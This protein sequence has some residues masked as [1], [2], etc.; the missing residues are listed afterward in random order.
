M[1]DSGMLT[2]QEL[3]KAQ[4][5]LFERQLWEIDERLHPRVPLT[6]KQLAVREIE[7]REVINRASYRGLNFEPPFAEDVLCYV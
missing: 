4:L 5:F 2:S 6:Q 7:I 1:Y 3:M